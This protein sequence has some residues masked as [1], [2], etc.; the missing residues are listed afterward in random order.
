M[1]ARLL[2]HI[3][4]L[5][6]VLLPVSAFAAP[7]TSSIAP[8][9]NVVGVTAALVSGQRTAFPLLTLWKPSG[10]TALEAYDAV[11]GKMLRAELDE[12][13]NPS[14]ADFPLA[15]NSALYLYATQLNTLALGEQASCA[16]LNLA[17]GFNL[18]GYSCFPP[19]YL[20]SAFLNSA[21]LA[22]ITSLSRLD[23]ETGR[24]QTAAVDGGVIVGDD[25]PL[26]TGEGYII[27]SQ[28]VV[29][30]W[31]PPAPVGIALT[32]ATLTVWQGEPVA[33]L[34]VSLPAPAPE[35]GTTIDLVSSDPA[36]VA[37]A[38]QV[39]VAQGNTSA[40]VPLTVPDSGGA[41][42]QSVSITAT[43]TG[44]TGAQASLTLRPKPTLSLSPLNAVTGPTLSYQLT[45]NLSDIAPP[46]GLPVALDV[47]PAGIVSVP[48]SVTVPAGARS[49][50]VSVAAS[51]LG[52]AT[53][54]AS[55]P[56]RGIGG[57]QHT[58]T[59]VPTQSVNYTP[60]IS[61][62]IGVQVG[63]LASAPTSISPTYTPVTSAEVGVQVGPVLGGISP[64]QTRDYGPLTTSQVGVMV[65]DSADPATSVSATY[66]PLATAEVG[67]AVGPVLT[68]LSPNHGAI[69]STALQLTVNGHGLNDVTGMVF[70]PSDG[71][72]VGTIGVAPDG[73]SVTAPIDI[74]ATAPLTARTVLLTTASGYIM[75]SRGGADVFRVTLPMPEIYSIQP[76][77][78]MVGQ[79][80]VLTINGKNLTSAS[81]VDCTPSTGILINNPPAVSPDGNTVTVTL[82]VASSAPLGSRVITVTT[83]GGVTSPTASPANTFSVTADPGTSFSAFS[84]EVGVMVTTGAVTT[85]KDTTYGPMASLPVGVTVGSTIMAIAPVSGAIG[86][87]GIKVRALGVA[88]NHASAISFLPPEGI[89]IQPSS[90]AIGS[91]GNPEVT[92]DIAAD[93]AVT[94]RTVLVALESGDYA[95][96]TDAGSNLFRV[97]L[98]TPEIFS[99]QPIRAMVGQTVSMTING[100]NFASAGSVD[101]TP[102]SGITVINPPAVSTDGT[103]L[104]VTIMIAADAPLGSRVVTVTTPG[105]ISSAVAT[106]ANTF[107]VTSDPGTAYTPLL[108]AQI[109]IFVALT[110]DGDRAPVNYGPICS[111]PVGIMV[112][113]SP[114]PTTVEV[115]YGP[116]ASAQV[117]VAVGGV[118]TG[119]SR[120]NLAEVGNGFSPVA[121][122]PGSSV[123]FTLTGVGL[124]AVTAI[125]LIPADNITATAWTP[126]AG[127][128]SG[129]VTITASVGAASVVRTLVPMVENM[130]LAPSVGGIDI[131]QVGYRPVL[132]SVTTDYP[133]SSLV[134]DIG[135]TVTLT[136]NGDH[137]QGVTKVELVPSDGITLDSVPVWFSNETGEHVRVTMVVASNAQLGDR[138]VLLTTPYGSS[139]T[140]RDTTNTLSIIEPVTVGVAPVSAETRQAVAKKSPA[141]FG[142]DSLSMARD[143]E[144]YGVSG[145][146]LDAALLPT[147]QLIARSLTARSVS[148]IVK[149]L[150]LASVERID[151]SRGPPE[152]IG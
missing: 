124:D 15:E 12:S 5:L 78:A 9:L 93:A 143:L 102:P 105:G 150:E 53:V 98:P 85:T 125:T 7:V 119:F 63:P 55:S 29:S 114:A 40:S 128:R 71:I 76:I 19:D 70:I 133:D 77:R 116:V 61:S 81:S 107:T 11:S 72:T 39:T 13:G 140:T 22:H 97:T 79:S 88:L 2:Q 31:T 52:S 135:T 144:L 137:L 122:E 82:N 67:V 145:R 74:A 21:G 8:G 25:F 28:A 62:E 56:G 10:V 57:P 99:I 138:L 68:G 58:V 136:L 103:S 89:T 111:A 108:S 43:R 59:V 90:F 51:A 141:S 83:P 49:A 38:A 73:L 18:A 84:S 50:Q 36:L 60:L 1:I 41:G 30:G 91:D 66:T 104:T 109:G 35:G 6:T 152:D 69:G 24:W 115:N 110:P 126:A 27:Q 32:P 131:L 118:F 95:L 96:P 146:K 80:V 92:I 4:L 48:A 20:A 23:L 117:G 64:I 129:T 54:S 42:V 47:S 37:V 3:I 127:G 149:H 132:E 101:F 106:P 120:S 44:V 87:T 100:K 147:L 33:S 86:A 46:G 94:P 121:L 16:P 151:A 148:G 123:N 26:L 17:A 134:A 113:P 142:S 65:G 45:V 14:G 75:S 130:A 34:T 139:R 112:T